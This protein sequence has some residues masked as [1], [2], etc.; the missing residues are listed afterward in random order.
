MKLVFTW[1]HALMDAP[2]AEHFLALLGPD[3]LPRPKAEPP[4]A[5]RNHVGLPARCKL[6]WKY[7]HHT[8]PAVPCGA[9]LPRTAASGTPPALTNYRVEL[10]SAEESGLIRANS[11]R[12]CGILGAAQYHAAVATLE[13]HQLHERLGCPSPSYVIPLPVGLRHKGSIEPLFSNQV[14]MLMLQFLPGDL[15]SIST[16]VAALKNQIAQ[17][18]REGLS[19]TAGCW[20]NCS[21]FCR[22]ALTCRFSSKVFAGEICSLFYGDTAAVSPRLTRFLG[23]FD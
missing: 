2:G 3:D 4:G 23:R 12:H 10:Y 15:Q 21:G 17:A 20:G 18:M 5:Q 14:G 19:R 22:C 9:A 13:L 7:L 11:L 16:A 6:A 1:A 8:R